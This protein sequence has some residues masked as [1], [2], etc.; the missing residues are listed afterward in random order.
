MKRLMIAGLVTLASVA[1]VGCVSTNQSAVERD[2]QLAFQAAQSVA[3][4]S[5]VAGMMAD[6]NAK[7]P[8]GWPD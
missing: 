1:M 7:P 3:V 2:W 5:I 4:F 6:G 8:E